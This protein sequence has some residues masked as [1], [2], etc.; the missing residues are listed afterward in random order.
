MSRKNGCPPGSTKVG[1]KC[2]GLKNKTIEYYH[3]NNIPIPWDDLSISN[4]EKIID[5]IVKKH[6]YARVVSLGKK[7]VLD[8]FT[9]QHIKA[10]KDNLNKE[11][12]DKFLSWNLYKIVDVTWKLV[13]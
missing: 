2:I 6:G 7:D 3:E 12:K 9:A 5:D 1:G 13:K 10:V 8:A 11:Y 4:R